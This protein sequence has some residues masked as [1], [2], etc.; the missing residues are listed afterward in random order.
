VSSDKNSSTSGRQGS[1]AVDRHL[2]GIVLEW[3]DRVQVADREHVEAE[4][5]RASFESFPASDPVAPSL[6]SQRRSTVR[7]DC[8]VSEDRLTFCRALRTDDPTG[9][10]V[11][12]EPTDTL[13]GET[14]SGVRVRIS[15]RTRAVDPQD[16][17][18]ESL[19]LPPEHASIDARQQER[20]IGS[21]RRVRSQRPGNERRSGTERRCAS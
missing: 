5:D 14:P 13:E 18:P 4:L 8:E 11:R 9:P 12:G 6:A 21:E 16:A 2:L 20:R 15:V 7:I 3:I 1:R 19:E 10:E 17:V